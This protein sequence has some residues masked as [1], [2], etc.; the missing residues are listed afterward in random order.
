[1]A[2]SLPLAAL[3]SASEAA[4]RDSE[5]RDDSGLDEESTLCA[6]S[7]M[8]SRSVYIREGTHLANADERTATCGLRRSGRR[9][10]AGSTGP[11]KSAGCLSSPV[12]EAPCIMRT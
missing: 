6:R 3:E 9:R 7:K 1:M 12:Q 4:Q 11:S 2:A 8:S 10:S 5:M